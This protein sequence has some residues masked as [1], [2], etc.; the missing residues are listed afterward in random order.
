[1]LACS[2]CSCSIFSSTSASWDNARDRAVLSYELPSMAR[3][4]ANWAVFNASSGEW[5]EGQEMGLAAPGAPQ[6]RE[7][8]R[9]LPFHSSRRYQL[10]EPALAQSKPAASSHEEK[11]SS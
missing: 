5:D 2:W 6:H 8:P 4:L 3:L 10:E 1:M 7:Q 11:G 9:Q